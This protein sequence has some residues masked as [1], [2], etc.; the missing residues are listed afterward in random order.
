MWSNVDNIKS[1]IIS[2]FHFRPTSL[3]L[4]PYSGGGP[5]GAGAIPAASG[6]GSYKANMTDPE[7]A[8]NITSANPNSRW[9]AALSSPLEYTTPGESN[10]VPDPV[11]GTDA[12]VGTTVYAYLNQ[13]NGCAIGPVL[14]NLVQRCC[15]IAPTV[16]DPVNG[17]VPTSLAS[18]TNLLKSNQA[19]LYMGQS[20]YICKAVATD[21]TS[22]L[23]ISNN[24]PST[25]IGSIP[26]GS[27]TSLNVGSCSQTYGTS[28]SGAGGL[29]D[30]KSLDGVSGA[31]NNLHDQPFMQEQGSIDAT[32][33]ADFILSSGYQNLLGKLDFYQTIS[34]NGGTDQ[35]SRPN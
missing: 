25:Y 32:D 2:A 35:F 12:A 8:N 20:L 18:V 28:S 31:D 29:L 14:T 13:V 21:P 24:Q 23:V 5:G 33:H 30:S 19:T 7:I 26:D 15:E 6:L 4:G 16:K 11:S 10:N 3:T 22:P 17:I 1:Q 27:N 9:T 34:T